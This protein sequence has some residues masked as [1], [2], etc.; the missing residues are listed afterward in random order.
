MRIAMPSMPESLTY[1]V[2]AAT[3]LAVLAALVLAAS[4][5]GNLVAALL[6]LAIAVAI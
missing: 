4:P 2:V 3:T 5:A 1:S 6:V